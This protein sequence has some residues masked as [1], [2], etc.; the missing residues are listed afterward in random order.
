MGSWAWHQ[1]HYKLMM[2]WFWSAAWEFAYW[3]GPG[4]PWDMKPILKYYHI[5]SW[6]PGEVG[7]HDWYAR[8]TWNKQIYFNVWGNVLF[9]YVGMREG[10][11]AWFLQVG[12]WAAG[13]S[14]GTATPGN[15][16]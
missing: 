11:S 6:H 15:W 8:V 7:E 14:F 5:N 12:G 13:L 9:G 4:C 16:I 3:I 1:I 2:G 10:F